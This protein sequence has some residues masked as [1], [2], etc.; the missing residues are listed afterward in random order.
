[1]SRRLASPDQFAEYDLVV[2]S[3]GT[4]I[5]DDALF[6]AAPLLCVIGAEAQHVK[7]RRT[8]NAKAL[9]S[10]QSRGRYLLTG[11]PVENS[12]EDLRS[13]VDFLMP[14]ALPPV[15]ANSRGDERFWHEKRFLAQAA[16][17]V[18]RRN[19][20]VVA[21]E[22]PDKI[23]Q[24]VYVDMTTE[25]R[26]TYATAKSSGERE[27]TGMEEAGAAEG[28]LRMK[29]LT[30][31]LRLRQTCCDPRLL[32]DSLEPQSSAKLAAFLEILYAALDGGGRLLCFSQFTS[33]LSL[34][35]QEL[36]AEAIPYCYL[37]GSSRDRQAQV[38]RFQDDDSIPLFLIS[39]KAGGVG[40]NLTGAD[41]VV[42]FDPWWN[43]AAEA[44]ATDRAH[45]I[46][47]IKTVHV[48]KLIATDSVEEN[49]LRLQT[50]KR[51]LLQDV[52]EASEIA[53]APITIDD[54]K[55]LL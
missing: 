10:L 54:L 4:L 14:G 23:E 27:I 16:P 28:A 26:K 11:T 45:R 40:L 43:P 19:K 29:T 46:G 22:L 36:D 7:N 42:H 24:V 1:G 51:K 48:H 31:L 41:H 3:Y 50:Q 6:A 33:L 38:D 55:A 32:D 21:P 20:K 17:Y 5:R 39:L 30:Q 44:Q 34:V 25:Q 47:Q 9:T 53:N 15:P 37:D 18:L 2:T 35:R 13:L 12:I 49:V 52:F 8:R